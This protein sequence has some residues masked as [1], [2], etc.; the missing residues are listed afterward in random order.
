MCP[1]TP[2]PPN[3]T[4]VDR[5]TTAD[6]KA[7]PSKDLTTRLRV[8]VCVIGGVAIAVIVGVICWKTKK[9]QNIT[10][11]QFHLI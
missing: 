10:A 8:I 5:N 2:A 1:A 11:C 9:K 4:A 6:Q 3:T 7:T